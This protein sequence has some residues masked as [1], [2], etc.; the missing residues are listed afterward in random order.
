[1]MIQV[2]P[3][4]QGA[5]DLTDSVFFSSLVD[6]CWVFWS[7][8]IIWKNFITA[9]CFCTR[10]IWLLKQKVLKVYQDGKKFL[11]PIFSSL[12]LITCLPAMWYRACDANEFSTKYGYQKYCFLRKISFTFSTKKKK[13]KTWH[14]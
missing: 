9:I 13:W 6:P 2:L 12:F 3:H 7:L 5:T 14:D 1:M 11:K 10:R 8:D 4:F